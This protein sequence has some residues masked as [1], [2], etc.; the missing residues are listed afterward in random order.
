MRCRYYVINKTS[1]VMHIHGYCQNTKPRN[2][3]I[4]LFDTKEDLMKYANRELRMCMVCQ[5]M[6]DNC[7]E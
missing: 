4:R 2:F 3:A 1:S 7:S 5:K 6:L